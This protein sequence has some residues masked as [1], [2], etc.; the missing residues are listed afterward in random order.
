MTNPTAHDVTQDFYIK[1]LTRVV[2]I[3][4]LVLVVVVVATGSWVVSREKEMEHRLTV[5]EERINA[6]P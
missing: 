3:V 2:V 5:L 6:A 1:A 4:L